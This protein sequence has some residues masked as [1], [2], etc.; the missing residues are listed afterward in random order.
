MSTLLLSACG[1]APT[2]APTATATPGGFRFGQPVTSESAAMLAAS[3]AWR[4]SFE[5]D[6]SP[7][8]IAAQP[9]TYGEYSARFSAGSARPDAMK[10]WLVVYYDQAWQVHGPA[11]TQP[12]PFAGCVAVLLN[13]SDGTPLEVTGPLSKGSMSGCD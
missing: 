12:P 5:A 10:V 1:A 6:G 7:L 4:M 9:M 2:P 3:S 11:G 13:A 8:L